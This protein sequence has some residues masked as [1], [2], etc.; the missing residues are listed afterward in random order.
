MRNMRGCVLLDDIGEGLDYSRASAL[1]LMMIERA[2]Q[3][4][5][6]LIMTTNDRFVMNGVD[7]EYW[8]I[9]L[10]EGSRVQVFNQKNSKKAFDE[11]EF[12]GLNNFDFFSSEYF[13]SK[14]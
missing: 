3:H 9:L 7:L 4:Q 2:S 12:V 13:L 6:Q 5:F 8:S 1:V 14:N 10:R 11:F